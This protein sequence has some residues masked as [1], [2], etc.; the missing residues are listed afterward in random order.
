MDD[1]QDNSNYSRF[2]KSTKESIDAP[3]MSKLIAMIRGN[4]KLAEG[5]AGGA[6][7]MTPNIVP[8]KPDPEREIGSRFSQIE[9][10]DIVA[11]QKNEALRQGALN[12]PQQAA[13]SE[14]ED[15]ARKIQALLALRNSQNGQNNNGQ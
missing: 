5:I 4:P 15:R 11:M 8:S 14:D 12:P 1:Q 6:S 13:P 3:L 2:A 10:P 9:N 7:G